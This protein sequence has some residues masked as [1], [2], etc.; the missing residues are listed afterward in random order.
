MGGIG[1][2]GNHQP[3]K[4][5]TPD[6][7]TVETWPPPP[8]GFDPMEQ[9]AWFEIR[10]AACKAGTVAASDLISV[11]ITARLL[12]RV[13]AAFADPMLKTS[14]LNAL[15]SSLDGQLRHLGLQP[16]SRRA[17]P[18]LPKARKKEEADPIAEFGGD[19]GAADQE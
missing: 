19:E 7:L 4:G 15:V 6:A 17:V 11:K 18:A 13:E 9:T 14:T 16:I 1:S 5:S 8:E 12:A 3:H 10:D 2:G